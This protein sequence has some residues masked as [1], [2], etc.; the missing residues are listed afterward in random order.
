MVRRAAEVLDPLTNSYV[1]PDTL[2]RSVQVPWHATLPLLVVGGSLTGL[3]VSPR[4]WWHALGLIA[5]P[6][7]YLGGLALGLAL[8]ISYDIDPGLSGRYGLSV[9]PL[10]VLALAASLTGAWPKRAVGA[11]AVTLLIATLAVMVT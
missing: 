4:R 5:V 11:F 1:S 6:V 2:G 9:A 8:V 3:F 7:L 10:M